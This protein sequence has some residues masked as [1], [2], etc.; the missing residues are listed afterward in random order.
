MLS[1]EI[2]GAL[3]LGVLWVTA[4]LVAGAAW[5]DFRDLRA[6][7]KRAA[8]KMIEGVVKD[9]DFAEWS[10]EQTGR[11]TD[12]DA[13]AFHDREFHSEVFGGKIGEAEIAA[14][15]SG[16]VWI[17]EKTRE[18]AASC[19]DVTTYDAAHALA[20]KAKGFAR[21][22]RFRI[23][24]GQRV[25]VIGQGEIVAT[26]DPRAWASRKSLLVLA[27]IPVELALCAA[28]T[29]LALTLPRF[30]TMSII[31]A[32]ACIAFFLGVTPVA[33][34]IRE[35]VRRPHEAF[36]RTV[37]SR[38]ALVSARLPAAASRNDA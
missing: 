28:A 23:R 29:R 11:A 24:A 17:D 22:V 15:D 26:F 25:W 30:G 33:V 4:I 9:G 20:R 2:M 32:V 13:I 38:K 14:N 18:D 37:W 5:Q 36:L 1:R 21:T 19:G 10:V 8:K 16:E 6:V 3:C 27:F 35:S 7:V 31:G 12:D 34:A